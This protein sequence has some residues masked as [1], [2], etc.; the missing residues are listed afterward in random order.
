M[1]NVMPV[2]KQETSLN[3]PLLTLS[4]RQNNLVAALQLF[5]V[6]RPLMDRETEFCGCGSNFFVI[7]FTFAL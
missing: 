7:L 5:A 1:S 3:D 2:P 6:D 4:A